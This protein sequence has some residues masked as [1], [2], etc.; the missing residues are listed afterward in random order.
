MMSQPELTMTTGFTN[1]CYK[2]SQSRNF[3]KAMMSQPELTLATCT[4]GCYN[5]SL[6]TY[7]AN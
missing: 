2:K 7:Q 5:A 6:L 3:Q 1:G 4:N